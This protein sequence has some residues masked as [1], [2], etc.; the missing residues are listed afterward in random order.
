MYRYVKKSQT[1]TLISFLYVHNH[2]LC[3]FTLYSKCILCK[4]ILFVN[5]EPLG[6]KGLTGP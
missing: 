2:P 6:G 1:R 5:G 3:Y 4:T